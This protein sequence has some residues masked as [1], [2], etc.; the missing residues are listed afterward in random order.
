MKWETTTQT[1]IGLDFGFFN[2]RL[3]GTA[4][5]YIKKTKDILVQPPYLGIIGEGVTAG[6]MVLQWRIKVLKSV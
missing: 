1:N 3:Y 5:Y 4:E 6:I 2:Q